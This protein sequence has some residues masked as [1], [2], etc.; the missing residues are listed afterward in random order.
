MY[1]CWCTDLRC[2]PES[3]REEF[4]GI[5]TL[6]ACC[7]ILTTQKTHTPF[8]AAPPKKQTEQFG[9]LPRSSYHAVPR[10]RRQLSL[11]LQL[12]RAAAFV[13]QTLSFVLCLSV[14]AAS[15]RGFG[16]HAYLSLAFACRDEQE[17]GKT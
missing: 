16:M 8:A 15:E 1:S 13:A 9:R 6:A 17:L 10:I 14:N 7:E 12:E 4:F 3:Q 2:V 11:S 5:H